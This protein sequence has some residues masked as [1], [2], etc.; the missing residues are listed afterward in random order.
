MKR[1]IAA[2]IFFISLIGI[3]QGCQR[4]PVLNPQK[5]VTLT[6]WHNFGGQMRETM[7]GMVDEFNG[8]VGE[9]EGIIV[10][11]TSINSSAALHEKLVMAAKGDPGAPE[12]PDISTAN[13]K[14]AIIL[15]EEGVIT[16][17]GAQFTEKELEDYV[18]SFIEEGLLGSD[19]LYLFPFAKSTE[20]LFLNKTIFDRFA[21]D[22]QVKYEDLKTY[23]GIAK[24]A[25]LYYEWTDEKTPDIKND[26]KTFFHADSLFNLAQLGCRQLGYD[27]V[28][29]GKLDYSS[30]GF[31]R[32]WNYFYEPAVKGYFAIYDGY[33]SD[34]TKTGDIICSTGSTAGI[35]FF[36]PLVT[37]PDNT[38]ENA[39][40][41]VLPFP[42]FEGGKKV[43]LQRG[44]GMVVTKSTE[45]KEYAAGIFLKWFTSPEHNM[46]FINSTGY[47]PVTKK[48][49]EG[50]LS[51]DLGSIKD[52]KTK[53]LLGAAAP[54][55]S[56]YEFYVPEV[57]EGIDMLQR[58]Y[59]TKL[60][61]ISSEG[62]RDYAALLGS[63]NSDEAYME[64]SK[65]AFEEFIK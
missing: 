65:G 17:L 36:D 30:E 27:F 54:M 37:Y 35:A 53:V 14:T 48:A 31:K 62:R 2:I 64:A 60:R 6:L 47:L 29:Q 42:V 38:T 8:T 20:V 12:L 24:T 13:P 39:E 34:L 11:V 40:L 22:K 1:C 7:D 43:A 61:D 16:D 15:K 59:E 10:V 23:E 51:S 3:F 45:A 50:I 5:P 19:T 56:E 32:I 46:Q 44:S 28:N 41:M 57:F 26:G 21:R 9:K 58:D 18:P 63:M 49:F 52:E 55:Y 25:R 33:A 4:K